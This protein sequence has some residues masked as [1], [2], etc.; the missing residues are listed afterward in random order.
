MMLLPLSLL[1]SMVKRLAFPS[2]HIRWC[3]LKASGSSFKLH[4]ACRIIDFRNDIGSPQQ[5]L[6]Q[7]SYGSLEDIVCHTCKEEL[8]GRNLQIRNSFTSNYLINVNTVGICELAIPIL[9]NPWVLFPTVPNT[10]TLKSLKS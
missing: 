10:N 6:G 2:P 8:M 3:F 9:I 7:S 5:V 4:L 1:H